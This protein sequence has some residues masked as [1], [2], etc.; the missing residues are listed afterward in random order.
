MSLSPQVVKAFV[1]VAT[2]WGV[3]LLVG[4][5]S[6]VALYRTQQIERSPMGFLKFCFPQ[7]AWM[8]KSNFIDVAMFFG[9]K[10]IGS[11]TVLGEVALTAWLA[12]VVATG[13]SPLF[14]G[15]VA[16]HAGL[17]EI[18]FCGV[19]LF[20]LQD[21][22]NFYTHYLQHRVA[23]LW[24]LHKVHHSAAFLTPFTAYRNHPLGDKFDRLGVIL[25]SAIPTGAMVFMFGF[26]FAESGA[27][28]AAINV[29]GNVPTL[30]ALRHSHYPISFGP[31]DRVLVSPHMH[32]LHH[33]ARYEH[34]DK[35]FGN[36]LSIFDWIF[37]TAF[38]PPRDEA[39]TYGIGRGPA[40]DA[41][42]MTLSGVYIRPIIGLFRVLLGRQSPHELQPPQFPA[43]V[44]EPAPPVPEVR[45]A[46]IGMT[47]SMPRPSR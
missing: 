40:V 5:G 13:F 27:I 1:S 30:A 7:D 38:L 42:Y 10:L 32:Q 35:N 28:L 33:S 43:A 22:S 8:S 17:L 15:H 44:I 25:I 46:Y 47:Q 21:F 19:L 12:S 24:E 16:V 26:S 4:I 9:G 6:Y 45:S 18:V 3:F 14:P 37:G 23:F 31:L 34:W 29:F 2:I 36:K 39:L 20:V 11:A 41:Q